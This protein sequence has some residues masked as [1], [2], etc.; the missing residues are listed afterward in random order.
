MSPRCDKI[1]ETLKRREKFWRKKKMNEKNK[2][3]EA[4]NRGLS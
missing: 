3:K 4:L 2:S 1:M